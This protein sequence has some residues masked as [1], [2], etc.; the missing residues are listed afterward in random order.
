MVAALQVVWLVLAG[1]A[2]DGFL[3]FC[4]DTSALSLRYG[5]KL[6]YARLT[7]LMH[8]ADYV[9][10]LLL[11]RHSVALHPQTSDANHSCLQIITLQR[12]VI[13]FSKNVVYKISQCLISV[14]SSKIDLSFHYKR[15]YNNRAQFKMHFGV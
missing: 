11:E 6:A 5:T 9:Q 2:S 10:G 4:V 7:K 13:M 1:R 8:A 14:L 15:Q 3:Y 12:F